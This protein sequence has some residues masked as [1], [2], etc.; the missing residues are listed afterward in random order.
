MRS[1]W[2]TLFGVFSAASKVLTERIANAAFE[3]VTRLNKEHFA[4]IVR[5][6]AFA[7]LTV[8]ITEFCKVSKYQKISL[9]AI[10]MLRG[11][12]P[13]MLACPEC[14]PNPGVGPKGDDIMIRF[15]FPVLF[16]F[17]DIIMNGE[18]LEVRRLALDS[19][20]S[21]LKTYGSSF[22]VEFWD[23]VCKEILFPIFAVLKSSQ[24]M[25]RFNTQE[26]MSVWLSTTMIQA[27][28]DLIDL[29]TFFYDILERFLDGLLELL[30]VCI[31]QEN[32]TLARIGTSCLQQFLENNVQKLSAAWW[33]RVAA[34][35]V[36]LFRT[37][38]PHQLFDENLR[39]EIDGSTVSDLPDT[40][41]SNDQAIIPAPLSPPSDRPQEV[42]HTL[43]DRRRIFKQI[44]VKCVLQLLLI[45]TTNDLLR[46]NAVYTTIPPEQ[47]LRLMGVLDHSYQFARMFNDD[48]E[49]RTGLW[50]V[51]FMK[52]LPNLLKQESSSA[53]TLV[54][55]LLRMYFDERPEHQNA[56]PQIAE[57]LL[58]LGLS[59]LQ[60]YI[61]LRADTQ[62]KNI[63][64]WTPVV[65]EI[66]DGFCRFD[67]KA[68]VRYLPAIYPLATGLLARDVAPEIRLGLKMYF[69]RVGR[70]QGIVVVEAS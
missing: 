67:N 2:R 51:G 57:R 20:F 63:T 68:F 11:V 38:T 37:T 23:T 60:D 49:L 28:R 50:K 40:N 30:C 16:G 61:K 64:A 43:S 46:N 52:H 58:P 1:G 19:L 54:H 5:H 12:I 4:A 48:K 10:G 45:E 14:A 39:V 70:T 69:E 21:T 18:D 25:T 56:R 17:Y 8:C 53:A 34:T 22:N 55:V 33:E 65:A 26:D 9:L 59:V 15:W 27:L 66:L 47:L 42:K 13:V 3:I 6:G 36:K 7:D 32:D 41:D 44:I 29:Y 62:A 31:C 24:D 35:F